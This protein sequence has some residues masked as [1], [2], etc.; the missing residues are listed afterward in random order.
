MFLRHSEGPTGTFSFQAQN[1]I[2]SANPSVY[3]NINII[4]K[5]T[6]CGRSKNHWPLKC[7]SWKYAQKPT[8]QTLDEPR[9]HGQNVISFQKTL[10]QQLC[11]ANNI[12][13][14]I[15]WTNS[16]SFLFSNQN[17][18]FQRVLVWLVYLMNFNLYFERKHKYV[19][20][21][22]RFFTGKLAELFV[23]V[24]FPCRIMFAKCLWVTN[25]TLCS[26]AFSG[27]LFDRWHDIQKRK[28][29]DIGWCL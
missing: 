16:R 18:S 11:R 22:R 12:L 15:K 14:Q 10:C 29:S 1:K 27:P 2:L 23:C 25:K 17:I 19:F 9:R 24:S 7:H 5:V 6:F 4:R 26:S 3:R 13:L 28:K 20:S 21:C 8:F